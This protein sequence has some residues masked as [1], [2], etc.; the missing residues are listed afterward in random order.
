MID[1]R[2]IFEQMLKLPPPWEVSKVEVNE[3]TQEVKVY[4]E[5]GDEEAACP[6]TG[7]ICKIY[8]R[9]E[10]CWRHL[11][12]MEY[13]TLICCR[14]PRVKNSFGEYHDIAVDWAEPSFSHTYKFENKCI[15]VLQK[16]HCQQSAAHIMKISDDK[17]CG[18]MHKAVNRGLSRRDLTKQPVEAISIDEKSYGKGQHYIS[19]LTDA[20]NGRVLD[21][22]PGRLEEDATALIQKVF[23]TEQLS[24]IK[25]VC[26]DMWLDYIKALKKTVLMLNWCM[27][28]FT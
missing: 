5:Y 23:N 7:E 8:D 22:A 25:K 19:V 2:K 17:M 3:D 16:T 10:R 18:I 11:D 12:T 6:Q 20:T 13:K 1:A 9:R 27:I 26:C 4:I 24:N 15:V 28:S 21:V 14:L